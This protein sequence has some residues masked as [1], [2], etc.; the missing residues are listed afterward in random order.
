MRQ[1]SG[2]SFGGWSEE[3]VCLRERTSEVRS[4]LRVLVQVKRQ[5]DLVAFGQG[6]HECDQKE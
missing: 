2:A 6:E 3:K 4:T 1:R 5:R